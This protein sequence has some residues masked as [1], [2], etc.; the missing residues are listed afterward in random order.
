MS[1]VA[2]E[3]MTLREL[4]TKFPSKHVVFIDRRGVA[5]SVPGRSVASHCCNHFLTYDANWQA[6]TVRLVKGR[7]Q[8]ISVFEPQAEEA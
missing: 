6:W 4:I 2:T 1:A 3:T 7:Y 5:I 8:Q